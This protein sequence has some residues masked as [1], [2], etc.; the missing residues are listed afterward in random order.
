MDP[1]VLLSLALFQAGA[2]SGC[3]SRSRDLARHLWRHYH[4]KFHVFILKLLL[5]AADCLIVIRLLLIGWGARGRSHLEE[6]SVLLFGTGNFAWG[7]TSVVRSRRLRSNSV[8]RIALLI[9]LEHHSR[10]NILFLSNM[11]LLSKLLN[12]VGVISS[13]TILRFV[14]NCASLILA[15]HHE[16]GIF[17][18]DSR[19]DLILRD[20]VCSK[21]RRCN[22][23]VI[24]SCLL[25]QLLILLYLLY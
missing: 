15:C 22:L 2:S 8:C 7:D 23:R 19:I 9:A 17:K 13:D 10:T 20:R 11:L 14:G 12:V 21:R 16:I 25:L 4:P 5:L 1:A 24:S 6:R 3:I 18:A